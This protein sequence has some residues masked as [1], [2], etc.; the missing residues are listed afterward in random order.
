M[1]SVFF[2]C[3]L[4]VNVNAIFQYGYGGFTGIMR[5]SRD[6]KYKDVMQYDYKQANQE[7]GSIRKLEKKGESLCISVE[8]KHW[9]I[10]KEC[11]ST[12]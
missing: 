10:K 7:Q 1:Q 4:C 8:R 5:M 6:S 12:Y 9:H 11:Y 3:V 2:L